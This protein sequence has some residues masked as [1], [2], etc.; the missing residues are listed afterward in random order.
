MRGGRPGCCPDEWSSTQSDRH[1]SEMCGVVGIYFLAPPGIRG[2]FHA[3]MQHRKSKPRVASDLSKNGSPPD[4]S[5]TADAGGAAIATM[6]ITIPFPGELRWFVEQDDRIRWLKH[7]REQT[8]CEKQIQVRQNEQ[9]NFQLHLHPQWL[10]QLVHHQRLLRK[11]KKHEWLLPAV[12]PSETLEP[13]KQLLGVQREMPKKLEWKLPAVLPVESAEPLKNK[14][15]Q[16]PEK[17]E[18]KL[19]AILPPVEPVRNKPN[20]DE[21]KTPRM[22]P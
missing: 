22:L 7:I 19:P 2:T 17:L 21:G 3:R 4:S 8:E 13:L 9:A 14:L 18:W 5:S 11:R 16:V 10:I 15:G 1:R 6:I 20:I 12:M